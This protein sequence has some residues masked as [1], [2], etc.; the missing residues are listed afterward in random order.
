MLPNKNAEK[1]PIINEKRRSKKDQGFRKFTI[2]DARN[3]WEIVILDFKNDITTFRI[4]G[5]EDF[6]F[7]C[8]NNELECYRSVIV[9]EL[10]LIKLSCHEGRYNL[11]NDQGKRKTVRLNNLK[12]HIKELVEKFYAA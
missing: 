11:V 6:F 1:W 5:F 8:F 9:R 2:E 10:D 12:L 7:I 4:S 3:T